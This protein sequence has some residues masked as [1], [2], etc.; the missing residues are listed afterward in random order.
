M[1]NPWSYDDMVQKQL[2]PYW[3]A[4]QRVEQLFE[5]IKAT[6]GEEEAR[7]I[8]E[9][10][11]RPSARRLQEWRKKKI[12]DRLDLMGPI[13]GGPNVKKLAREIAREK[14]QGEETPEQIQSVER[15]IWRLCAEREEFRRNQESKRPL[16]EGG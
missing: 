11:G 15:H 10:W 5:E 16:I 13:G 7:S 2:D 3:L 8:F 1:A 6:F 12:L 14:H 9:V 4:E